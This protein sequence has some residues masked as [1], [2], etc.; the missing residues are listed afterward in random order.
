V[1]ARN[2]PEK[3]P[4]SAKPTPR[5]DPAAVYGAASARKSKESAAR[6]SRD[7]SRKS[8]EADKKRAAIAAV[9]ANNN[10]RLSVVF[11]LLDSG[12]YRIGRSHKGCQLKQ[13]LN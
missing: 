2:A 4:E 3:R 1:S 11:I 8:A 6:R 12:N 13:V 10:V 5:Y 9:A 7:S